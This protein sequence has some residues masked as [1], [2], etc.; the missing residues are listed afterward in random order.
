MGVPRREKG[1]ARLI[2]VAPQPEPADFDARV[3]QPGL[4]WIRAQGLDLANPM[5]T[6]TTLK[7]CWRDCLKELHK[8]YGG[9]CAYA[10]LYIPR[11]TGAR[12]VDHFVAKSS[13]LDQAYEWSNYRLACAKMNARKNAFDDVL[14]PF[15]LV[16]ETFRLNLFT[17]AISP[18]PTLERQESRAAQQTIDRLGL[19]DPD[20]REDRR[21]FFDEYTSGEISEAQLQRRAPFVWQEAQR[22]GLL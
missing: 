17:G 15:A 7:P 9:V 8:V 2:P 22:P 20:C 16:P 13:A 3:R 19:D 21:E 10:C 1:L 12:S 18:N 11:T 4:N 14:D 5:P 6:G